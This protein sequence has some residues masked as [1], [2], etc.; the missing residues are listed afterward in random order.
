MLDGQHPWAAASPLGLLVPLVG[1]AA[2]SWNSD[3]FWGGTVGEL[4]GSLGALGPGY[5]AVFQGLVLAGGTLGMFDDGEGYLHG[6]RQT[7]EAL[8]IRREAA[9]VNAWLALHGE[10]SEVSYEQFRN[11]HYDQDFTARPSN[12]E[13]LM[14]AAAQVDNLGKKEEA[15][16]RITT[17]MVDGE[18]HYTVVIPSTQEGNPY[19]NGSTPNDFTSDVHAMS[20]GDQTALAQ[21]TYAAMAQAQI[22]PGAPVMLV[23][24]S[25]GGIT[26]G[27]IAACDSDYDTQQVVT[28]G[29]PIANFDIPSST[30]VL[31]LEARQDPVAILDGR[32]N[33][34][35][36]GRTTIRA[37]APSLETDTASPT[38]LNAHDAH[39]YAS[40]GT[41]VPSNTRSDIDRFLDGSST[42]KDYYAGRR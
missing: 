8:A 34:D 37:D 14:L 32:L 31:S 29:S 2:G 35:V 36:E 38:P 7:E 30:S 18:P 24:F 3:R 23:G 21:A 15:V 9:A 27:A 17:T 39:R 28:G 10:G 42:S 25:L 19:A 33:P 26:A 11:E 1:N 4:E 13:G 16:I 41:S 5:D 12:V 20:A 40:M 22:P 6:P